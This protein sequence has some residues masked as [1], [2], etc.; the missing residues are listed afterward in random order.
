MLVGMSLVS[1]VALTVFGEDST[2]SI[3][4]VVLGKDSSISVVVRQ[5]RS[6]PAFRQ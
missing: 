6:L 2:S 5:R 3:S 1:C 4:V